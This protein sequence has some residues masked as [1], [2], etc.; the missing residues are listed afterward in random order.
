MMVLKSC[1][2]D[3]CRDPWA[4]LHPGGAVH[5]I[6]DALD[7]S[8][9]KFYANQ[10]RVSYTECSLGYHIWAEGPQKFNVYGEKANRVGA[11]DSDDTGSS[12]PIVSFSD[13]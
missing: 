13:M 10:P 11:R 8:F 4:Q 7:K 2:E 5:N 6:V 9:D 3:A 1:T 12:G